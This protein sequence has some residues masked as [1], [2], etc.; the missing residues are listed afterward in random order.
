MKRRTPRSGRRWPRTPA[1]TDPEVVRDRIR[2]TGA[3]IPYTGLGL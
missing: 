2:A 3:P 1:P